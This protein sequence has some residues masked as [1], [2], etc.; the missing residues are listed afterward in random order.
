MP[1]AG[2]KRHAVACRPECVEGKDDLAVAGLLQDAGGEQRGHVAVHGLDVAADPAR[3]LPDRKRTAARHGAD[4]LPTLGGHQPEQELGRREADARALPPAL[5]GFPRAA[6]DLVAAG[7]RQRYRPHVIA[8]I[9][10][11]Q[12]EIVE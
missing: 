7:D 9:V 2:V 6:L 1:T 12:Q 11:P 4:Q 3:C 10:R 8:S 5:E